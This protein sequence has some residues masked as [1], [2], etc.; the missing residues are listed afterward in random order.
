MSGSPGKKLCGI[1]CE[2]L[3][4]GSAIVGMGVNV[5]IPDWELP[6]ERATSLLATGAVR[7]SDG[8]DGDSLTFADPEGA[9]LAD[10]VV[11]GIASELVRLCDLAAGNP[12]AV[13]A[14]VLRSSL[15]LGTEVR[16]HLPDDDVVDGRARDLASDG[17]LI[18]DLPTG[19][20]LTVSAGDVQHLR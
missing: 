12:P 14:R 4:D 2:L 19:G 17:S 5:Y 1:L 3:P 9:A 20:Q 11:S 7:C 16:V 13:R 10:R 15:T 8:S 18:V 6:T